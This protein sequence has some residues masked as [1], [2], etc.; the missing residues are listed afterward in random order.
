MARPSTSSALTTA[1]HWIVDMDRL[2][3]A[4]AEYLPDAE[5]GAQGGRFSGAYVFNNCKPA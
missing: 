3:D 5:T 1:D 4:L 2:D